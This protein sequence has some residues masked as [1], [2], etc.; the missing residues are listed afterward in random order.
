MSNQKPASRSPF[1]RLRRVIV[2]L[3]IAAVVFELLYLAAFQVM[4]R[5][6]RLG[7][8][9]NRKPEKMRIEWASARSWL[10]G[11]VAVEDLT[12]TGQSRKVQWY[13]RVAD[14]RARI[15]LLPLALKQFRVTSVDA[16]GADF[17]LRERLDFIREG[18]DAPKS[19]RGAEHFPDIP[20]LNNPPDP[21]PE[22]LYPRKKK[23]HRPWTI[24]LRGVDI[25]GP[26][27]VAVNRMRLEGEGAVSGAMTY[28]LR[29]SIQIR[30]AVLD[31]ASTQVVIDGEL[32]S[33]DL[34]L[35]VDTR[36]KAFAPKGTKFRQVLGGISGTLAIAGDLFAKASV[37][38]ELVPGLPISG[39]GRLDTT[40]RLRDGVLQTGSTYSLDSD[41][42]T[43]GLLGLNAVGS[44]KVSGSTGGDGAAT[45]LN[46]DLGA[47]QFVD[48]GNAVTGVDG[49]GLTLRA[50]W[51][52]LSLGESSPPTSV[53]VELPKAEIT[54]VRVVGQLL[55]PNDKISIESGTGTV[56]GRL[57]VDESESA[58]GKI[59][60]TA[61]DILLEAQGTPLRADL[62]VHAKLDRGSLRTRAF[63]VSDTTIKI[64]DVVAA[65]RPSKDTEAWWSSVELSKGE[66]VLA[67]PISA[68][69]SVRLAMHDTGPVIATIGEF[70]DLPRWM[71]L[72]PNVKN[73]E[74]S[75]EV[76]VKQD[77]M[78]ADRIAI[79]GDSLEILGW[80]HVADK[81][82][83]GRIYVKYKGLAAGIGL[84]EGRSKIHLMKPRQ[85]FNSQEGVAP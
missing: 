38:V 1:S 63:E 77:L 76:C 5:T 68:S 26:V 81:R 75:M 85:W 39:T 16:S 25:A 71:S 74:G 11:L 32:A 40:L 9:I 49:S 4:M 34:T 29:E 15:S 62:A 30:R 61:N 41:R 66:A 60:L 47:F 2:G 78:S 14:A 22:D 10:P 73:I 50:V 23:R 82:P 13:L 24:D 28:R 31:L 58:S 69:G 51:D 52:T 33:A 56:S 83:D 59:D 17:R 36:W 65:H 20:G 67:K 43:I 64:S 55:P 53:D 21:K 48:P 3:V 45:E 72:I 35:D 46:V 8:L 6:G 12:M 70:A 42:F 27:R 84:D 18:E 79:T 80:L 19:I 37:P 7:D 44:A 57:S 54:D